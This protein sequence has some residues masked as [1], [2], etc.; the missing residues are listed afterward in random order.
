MPPLRSLVV[1][2]IIATQ[3]TMYAL[4][5]LILLF[6]DVVLILTVV[7]AQML[8]MKRVAILFGGAPH[9][10]EEIVPPSQHLRVASYTEL[11]T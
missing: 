1:F 9:G 3:R 6:S 10:S 2:T 4:I 11:S 7:R 5:F 8:A